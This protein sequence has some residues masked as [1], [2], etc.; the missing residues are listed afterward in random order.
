MAH[1]RA[2]PKDIPTGAPPP[3]RL[4]WVSRVIARAGILPLK[5]AEDAVRAGR[6]TVS[7]RL[8]HQPLAAVAPHDTVRLDGQKVQVRPVTRVL[9][10]HKPRGWVTSRVDPD[11]V[12]TVFELLVSLLTP[13]LGSFQWHAIGRLDRDTTGLLLFTNDEALVAHVTSPT[14]GLTKLYRA[15]VQGDLTDERLQPLRTGVPLLGG[16]SLPAK[17]VIVGPREVELTLTEGKNHQVKRMLGEVGLPVTTL[18]RLAIGAVRLDVPE[19]QMRELTAEEISLG[20]GYD[21]TARQK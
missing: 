3:L 6:V 18:E 5:Q 17:A 7:G 9:A 1:R 11:G 4:D 12:G 14:T 13:E 10:F 15:T 21:G 2:P 8:V 19:R 16:V 20:L